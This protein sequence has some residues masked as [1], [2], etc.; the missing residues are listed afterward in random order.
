VID[1]D[2]ESGSLMAGQSVGFVTREQST[3][4]ILEELVDQ[5]LAVL[6]A[7]NKRGQAQPV[8]SPRK[9]LGSQ[10]ARE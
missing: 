1:G 4:E 7:R 6:A 9:L 8:I 2:I 5:A 3:S 10:D